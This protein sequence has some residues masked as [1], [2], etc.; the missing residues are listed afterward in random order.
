[1]RSCIELYRFTEPWISHHGVDHTSLSER[2][3]GKS[4]RDPHVLPRSNV[5]LR[6]CCVFWYDLDWLGSMHDWPRCIPQRPRSLGYRVSLGY[7]WQITELIVHLAY[8][9]T[10]VPASS[11]AQSSRDNSDNASTCI[12]KLKRDSTNTEKKNNNT[13]KSRVLF[14]AQ[15]VVKSYS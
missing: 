14:P 12:P 10:L 15:A 2:T 13:E 3:A 8:R 5:H 9:N 1:M 6:L 7:E 4:R 11:F